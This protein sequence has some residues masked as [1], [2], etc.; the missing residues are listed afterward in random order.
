MHMHIHFLDWSIL[1]PSWSKNKLM[2]LAIANP[3]Q[4]LVFDSVM[5][6]AL[7]LLF[8]RNVLGLDDSQRVN[9][10]SV[11]LVGITYTGDG[12][13]RPGAI[14]FF[15]LLVASS[16]SA[17]VVAAS[18]GRSGSSRSDATVAVMRSRRHPSPCSA[19]AASGGRVTLWT[20]AASEGVPTPEME[21]GGGADADA[22][23]PTPWRGIS[24][25]R[26]S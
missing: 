14:T 20:A 15:L 18:W 17:G 3:L 7:V 12:S 9:C 6:D 25:C 4:V 11:D 22:F 16:S 19:P 10:A 5:P 26:G 24:A 13:S 21:Q 8:L 2:L 1:L 23:V